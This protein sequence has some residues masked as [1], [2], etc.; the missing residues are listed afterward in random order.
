MN[1]NVHFTAAQIAAAL[2]S[3]R[4][5]VQRALATVREDGRQVV[6]GNEAAAWSVSSLPA[7]MQRKLERRAN[8]RGFRNSEHLLR[9]GADRFKSP[10]PVNQLAGPVQQRAMK[11]R[12]ALARLLRSTAKG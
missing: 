6:R 7:P 12:D 1:S 9:A 10:V 3:S 2:G 5:V 8:A 11:L 4:Q